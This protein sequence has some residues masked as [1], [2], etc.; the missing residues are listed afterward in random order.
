[1]P[2]DVAHER[3][4]DIIS[5]IDRVRHHVQGMAQEA[6]FDDKTRDAVER[7]LE[8]ISKQPR[9]SGRSWRSASQRSRGAAFVGWETS[10]G[11]STQSERVAWNDTSAARRAVESRSAV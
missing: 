7:C 1:M 10:S 3:L 6:E 4:P 5:N 8:R 9:N 2:S 11:M